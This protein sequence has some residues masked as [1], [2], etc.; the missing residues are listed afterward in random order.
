[1]ETVFKW[2]VAG[3]VVGVICVFYLVVRSW[4]I[5]NA[6]L[7]GKGSAL[8]RRGIGVNW[9]GMALFSASIS[10]GWSLIGGGIHRFL[11]SDVLFVQFSLGLAA[12]ITTMLLFTNTEHKLDKIALNA[13]VIVGFGFLLPFVR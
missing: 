13:I 2:L 8:Y 6:M 10:L 1:M 5:T 3:Y 12:V 9:L 4:I 11:G 7:H